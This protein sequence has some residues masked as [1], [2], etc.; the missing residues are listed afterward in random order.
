MRTLAAAALLCLCA[1]ASPA[2]AEIFVAS[3]GAI[4]VFADGA[5]GDVAPLRSIAGPS[6]QISAPVLLFLDLVHQE[7]FLSNIVFGPDPARLLVFGLGATGDATPLRSIS[8]ATSA[9]GNPR[10]VV[11]DLE[12][13]EL[14]VTE[15]DSS[16]VRVYARTADGDVAPLRTI[17]GPSTALEKGYEL[18]LTRDDELLVGCDSSTAGHLTGHAR[19]ASGDATPTRLI[20]G[21][22]PQLV[23]STGVVSSRAKECSSGRAVDGCLFRD[24]FERGSTCDWDLASGAPACS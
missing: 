24:G 9:I 2:G 12:H 10:S 22:N 18:V 19:S 21:T 8:G 14:F 15:Y 5:D 1:P 13:D 16:V 23:F 17:G 20:A 11:V 4:R 3:D 7:I 6:T